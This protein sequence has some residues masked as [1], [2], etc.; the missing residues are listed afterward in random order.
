M[1]LDIEWV[2]INSNGIF[3]FYSNEKKYE[4]V[5]ESIELRNKKLVLDI[6]N[7]FSCLLKNNPPYKQRIKLLIAER[8]AVSGKA[9]IWRD[10]KTNNEV[11][12]HH[13]TFDKILTN[14]VSRLEKSCE[15]QLKSFQ[16]SMCGENE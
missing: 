3:I 16:N 14:L 13:I 9:F 5:E 7:Y 2:E 10:E 15:K 6:K 4:K 11:L 1:K 12:F 8:Q